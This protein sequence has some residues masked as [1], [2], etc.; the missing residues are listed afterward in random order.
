MSLLSPVHIA[1]FAAIALL[2]LGPKRFP[3]FTKTIGNT[4]REFREVMSGATPAS[5]A[6]ADGSDPVTAPTPE[7]GAAPAAPPPVAD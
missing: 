7:P 5:A 4:V 1:F 6:E 2:V 3:D